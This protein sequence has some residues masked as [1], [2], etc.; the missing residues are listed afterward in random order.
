MKSLDPCNPQIE[1]K[2]IRHVNE[3]L[4]IR[5]LSTEGRSDFQL[6]I[7]K[8]TRRLVPKS[9]SRAKRPLLLNRNQRADNR[10]VPD[11]ETKD[12]TTDFQ[13]DSGSLISS[14]GI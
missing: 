9:D 2:G 11:E 4:I 12:R 7:K 1:N 5:P 13:V 6:G 8:P 3:T 10:P 14:A